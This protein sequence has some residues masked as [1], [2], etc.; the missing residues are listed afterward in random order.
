M[1]HFIF[2]ITASLLL[3]ACSSDDEN[4]E[5][6]EQNV[7]LKIKKY[8]SISFD[9]NGSPNGHMV[10][11]FFNENGKKT[12]DHIIDVF[13]DY[14]WEYAYNES[15]QVTKKSRKYLNYPIDIVENYMYNSENKLQKIFI[16]N[17]NN[18]VVEDSLKFTYQENQTIAQW[19]ST[20]QERKEFYYNNDGTLNSTKQIA[21]LGII[22]DELIV[23]DASSNISQIKVTTAYFNSETNHEY[24]YDG[25]NNPFY[26]E[27]H[28]FYFNIVR[29]DGGLL[30]S[31]SLFFSPSN[32]TKTTFISNDPLE[33]YTIT[34][35]Y[36]Y[37][38]SNYPVSSEKKLNGVLQTQGSYEYY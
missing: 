24:E 38:S 5:P 8:T 17:D 12:K 14:T 20:G 26:N 32:V 21:D 10:E 7:A 22:S 11:Y 19:H 16:D 35:S 36:E 28:D 3:L 25:K 33:N 31:H 27:F 1:K 34:S 13:G 23:H 9:E 29:R 2:L 6:E 15:G 4:P 30:S 37:D 18:G